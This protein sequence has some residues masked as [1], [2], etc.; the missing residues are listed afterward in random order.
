MTVSYSSVRCRS[1]HSA[2]SSDDFASW[3]DDRV[4]SSSK[5]FP[6][7]SSQGQSE[8]LVSPFQPNTPAA[9]GETLMG[10]VDNIME[11]SPMIPS[12]ESNG[13]EGSSDEE[14]EPSE[15]SEESPSG[16]L[17]LRGDETPEETPSQ[18]SMPESEASS[19]RDDSN[20]AFRDK[21][22][23]KPSDFRE[24]STSGDTDELVPT[25]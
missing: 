15:G 1:D 16:P 13:A 5:T 22:E 19:S 17:D 21:L 14:A 20:G 3:I 7:G 12:P 4:A 9:L 18:S 23:E 25:F 2:G 24:P 10:S 11:Q 6:E 8:P